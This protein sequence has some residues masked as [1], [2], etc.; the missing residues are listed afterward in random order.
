MAEGNTNGHH[1]GLSLPVNDGDTNHH[2]SSSILTLPFM[3]KVS[4]LLDS[5]YLSDLS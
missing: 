2:A 4:S 1:E 5:F 3:Q